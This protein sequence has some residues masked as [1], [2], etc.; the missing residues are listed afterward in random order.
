MKTPMTKKVSPTNRGSAM[1]PRLK[2]F[3]R[4]STSVRTPRN[5][6]EVAMKAKMG[7]TNQDRMIDTIPCNCATHKC[8]VLKL[9]QYCLVHCSCCTW[10]SATGRNYPDVWESSRGMS[11]PDNCVSTTNSNRHANHCTHCRHATSDSDPMTNKHATV[12]Q[13]QLPTM[14]WMHAANSTQKAR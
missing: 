6:M 7:E 14:L 4:R 12:L 5:K 2:L 9:K 11:V 3:L 10:R 1:H 13:L 8:S